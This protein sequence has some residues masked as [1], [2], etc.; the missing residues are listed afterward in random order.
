[1]CDSIVQWATVLSPVIAVILAWW[2]G[3]SSARNTAK[4]VKGIKK[5]MLIHIK[6]ELLYL[7]KEAKEEHAQFEILSKRSRSLFEQS[8]SCDKDW[9]F[10]TLKNH[11]EKE[12]D[13][14]DKMDY[15]FDR[16]KVIAEEMF[17]L[18]K[19]IREVEKV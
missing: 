11:R 5:L 2:T 18:S 16:R 19:L 7:E 1:M 4:L 3:R 14:E 10:E 17:E 13:V 9:S 8:V 6:T 12:R 15:T